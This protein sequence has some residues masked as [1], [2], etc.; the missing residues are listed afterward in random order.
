MI[1]DESKIH[2]K[3]AVKRIFSILSG[4]GY[5]ALLVILSLP[6][7][8]PIQIPGFSTP[9]GLA[10]AFLGL[11]ISFGKHLWWPK[12]VLDKELSSQKVGHLT[13]KTIIVFTKIQKILHPR[14]LVLIKNSLLHRLHG[15]LVF[16][17]AIFLSLPLPIPMTNMLT[18]LPIF[19]IGLGLLED[20]GVMILIGYFL[21]LVTLGLFSALFIFSKFHLTHIFS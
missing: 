3:I 16:T 18:A 7:C 2:D 6:F 1:V 19:C 9:F 12:R 5:A 4:K 17:L 11:R 13:E 15:L 20:D 21:A 8:I 14:F 10:L